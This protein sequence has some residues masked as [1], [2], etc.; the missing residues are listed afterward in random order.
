[1]AVHVSEPLRTASRRVFL[2]L[3]AIQKQAGD[4]KHDPDALG[5]ALLNSL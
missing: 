3:E 2:D 1:M 5:A 4:S